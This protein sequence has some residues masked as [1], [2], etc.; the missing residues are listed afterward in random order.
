MELWELAARE[1][2]RHTVAS[3]AHLVDA[4]RLDDVVQLFALDGVI[5]VV[6]GG[7]AQGHEALRAFFGGIG[8][9]LRS[10]RIPRIR[11]HTSNLRITAVEPDRAESDCYFLCL[12]DV[13][14]DHWGRYRDQLVRID[15]AWYFERR[16]VRTDGWV[17]GGWAASRRGD[18]P[19]SSRER[20]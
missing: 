5:D 18:G 17:E 6:D 10:S 11:H 13:G 3:Y 20:A 15:T 7:S 8:S 1:G 9:S 12:T 2:V 14:A 4:G 19:P 16:S